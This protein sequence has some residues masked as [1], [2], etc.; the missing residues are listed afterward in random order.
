VVLAAAASAFAAPDHV[1]T[2]RRRSALDAELQRAQLQAQQSLPIFWKHFAAH[3]GGPA[4][5]AVEVVFHT[6][7][8]IDEGIWVGALQ[9][10]GGRLSGSLADEPHRLP[11]YHM[12]SEVTFSESRIIDWTFVEGGKHYGYFTTR[13][14]SKLHPEEAAN[15]KTELWASPLPPESNRKH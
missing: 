3:P 1:D 6:P 8:G 12:N 5:H 10:M 15:L 2:I 11:G 14:L 9:R 13:V 7:S 4:D